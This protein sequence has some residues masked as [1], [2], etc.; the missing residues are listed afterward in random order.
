MHVIPK[1][2]REAI[3]VQMAE[4]RG[5]R[6]LDVRIWADTGAGDP[7]PTRQGV[8]V[9]LAAISTFAAAV[10]DVA[11]EARQMAE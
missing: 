2:G 4:F 5:A 6:Y 9:P 3:R 7:K 8:T 10:A 1:T 11:G